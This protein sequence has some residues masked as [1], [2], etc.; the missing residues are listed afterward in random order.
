MLTFSDSYFTASHAYHDAT[1]NE[2]AFTLYFFIIGTANLKN[3]GSP[4]SAVIT[5]LFSGKVIFPSTKSAT[6]CQ[7]GK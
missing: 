7:D 2:V 5:T 3:D 6:S 4:S 1:T